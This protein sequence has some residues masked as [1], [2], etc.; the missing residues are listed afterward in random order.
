MKVAAYHSSNP[1][2]PDVYHD[3][4]DCPTGPEFFKA[5][6]ANGC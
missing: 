3:H 6:E 1:P 2:D 5:D 4:D